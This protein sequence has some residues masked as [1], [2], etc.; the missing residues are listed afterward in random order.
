ML[1]R[2]DSSTKEKVY[3]TAAIMFSKLGY[4]NVSMTDLAKAAGIKSSTIHNHFKSKKDVLLGLYQTCTE[5]RKKITPSLHELLKLD[6]ERP[7]AEVL[8]LMGYHKGIEEA[9]NCIFTI[10]ARN[11]LTDM[12]SGQFVMDIVGAIVDEMITP[13]L[14]RLAELGRIEPIDIQAFSSILRLYCV[15]AAALVDTP[16]GIGLSTWWNGL[17]YLFASFVKPTGRWLH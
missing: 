3:R 6:K 12:D 2:N 10:A 14:P 9:L 4:D 5:Q 8:M 11:M 16:M 17:E 7:P 13:V 15:S 1:K